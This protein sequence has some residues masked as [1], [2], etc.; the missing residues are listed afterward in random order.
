MTRLWITAPLALLAACSSGGETDTAAEAPVALVTL[1]PATQGAA[2]EDM[3]L[4]GAVEPGPEGRLSLVAPAEAKVAEIRVAT[5]TT[6]RRGQI[7]ARLQPSA[8][9]RADAAKAA[10][11]AAAADKAFARA[12]R[13]RGDG[14]MSDADVET[15]RAAAA[16]AD[17]LRDS[18]AS[19]TAGFVLR[20]P[21]DGTVDTVAATVGDLLQAGAAVASVT[22]AGDLRVRFGLDPDSAQSVHPGMTIHIASAAAHAPIDVAV[23]TVNANV[24][25]QTRLASLYAH[26]PAA[27]GLRIGETLSATVPIMGP[28]GALTIPYAALLDDGGQPYV[29]VVSG[30]IAHRRD[31]ETAASSGARVAIT[32][33]VRAGERV[34]TAGGTAIEDGMKIRTR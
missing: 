17:A 31:V 34:V 15:T 9:G 32:K 11:D 8:Q 22:R 18:F 24:D 33:G 25:P 13:M 16:A 7:I 6:V 5:G 26:V 23:E 29:F 3:T 10:S 21:A 27:S 2:H 19:R 28:G 1:A 12:T 4:Y 20:A 14:L 30:G